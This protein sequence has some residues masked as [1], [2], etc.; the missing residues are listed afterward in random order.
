MHG[1]KI[2]AQKSHEQNELPGPR[3]KWGVER[4]NL[5]TDTEN[6]CNSASIS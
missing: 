2:S 4:R 3:S 5:R 1:N 6:E